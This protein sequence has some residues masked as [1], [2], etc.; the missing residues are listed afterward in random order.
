MRMQ[1]AQLFAEVEASGD[2]GITRQKQLVKSIQC[3]IS[4]GSGS[5]YANNQTITEST[6][7]TALIHDTGVKAGMWLA[8]AGTEYRV[9][10]VNPSGRF[11]I[12]YLETQGGVAD[13]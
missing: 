10:A 1:A 7:H 5:T 9:V 2:Y 8:Q 13:A 12:L 6:T 4:F 11:T 3:F